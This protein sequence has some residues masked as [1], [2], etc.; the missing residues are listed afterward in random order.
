VLRR[1]HRFAAPD[2]FRHTLGIALPLIDLDMPHWVLSQADGPRWGRRLKAPRPPA[3]HSGYGPRRSALIGELAGMQGT[4]RARLQTF[5]ASVLGSPL[6]LGALQTGIDRV[7]LAIPPHSEAMARLAR[8]AP[9][10]SMDATLWL[11]PGT[12]Q[13]LWGMTPPQVACS[14]SAPRRSTMACAALLDDWDGIVVRDG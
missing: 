8:H 3:P 4:S 1:Q 7:T 5:C 13:W 2:A 9:V 6:G 14:R 10:G 12:L 11:Y